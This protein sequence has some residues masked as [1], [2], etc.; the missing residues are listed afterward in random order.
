M[1]QEELNIVKL[2][3]ASTLVTKPPAYLRPRLQ[4]IYLFA[5]ALF[6]A[7]NAAAPAYA[8]TKAGHMVTGAITY[9]T[10]RLRDP[11]TLSKVLATL[12]QHPQY[13]KLWA[14]Q[15]QK[16]EAA[17][18]DRALCML[19]ARWADDIRQDPEYDRPEWHYI[20]SNFKPPGQPETL[21]TPAGREPNV[22]T[23]FR[24]SCDVFTR[25]AAPAERAVALCWLFHLVSDV[26][27]PLHTLSLL[28][29][30]YP[31]G[32]R[33]GNRFYIRVTQKADPINLHFFWDD[34]LIGNDDFRDA[35]NRAIEL[36]A[37]YPR[38]KFTQL[39]KP[40][41]PNQ[42]EDW[43]LESRALAQSDAYREGKLPGKPEPAKEQAPV[44]PEGYV[45]RVQPIARRQATLSGYRLADVLS[46]LL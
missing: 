5:A 20:S 8:W 31:D 38:E 28:T 30:D 9:D 10:L 42:F 35:R 3:P 4:P 33:G 6:L 27:Q 13:E 32:D 18:R 19:A 21:K 12:R 29:T 14:G 22:I 7:I 2:Q 39:A 25:E 15:L 46:K 44:L 43:V 40:A 24:A 23:A 34:L 26:H 1:Q 45:E 16:L 11:Q 17:D 41:L 37:A 36:R